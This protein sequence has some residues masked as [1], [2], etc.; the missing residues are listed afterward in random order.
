MKGNTSEWDV[1]VA[2]FLGVDHV[3][4]T[5]GPNHHIMEKKLSQMNDVISEIVSLIDNETILFIMG[6]HGMTE[7]G[8]HGVWQKKMM[9]EE[10]EE[11]E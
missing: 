10:E 4:H 8:N 6:D 1:I 2:H 11:E 5:F 9:K 7:D 3:G